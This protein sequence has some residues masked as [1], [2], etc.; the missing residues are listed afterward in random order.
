MEFT[1][2]NNKADVIQVLDK[3]IERVGDPKNGSFRY[4]LARRIWVK[5][6]IEKLPDDMQID[7]EEKY[8]EFINAFDD[9]FPNL[10]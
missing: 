7:W 5:S 2:I 10:P 8:N 9:N 3:L 4:A 1:V 6:Q